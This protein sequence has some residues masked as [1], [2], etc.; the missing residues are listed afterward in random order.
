LVVSRKRANRFVTYA[1]MYTSLRKKT[2]S[3]I[4]CSEHG[5]APVTWFVRLERVSADRYTLDESHRSGI[6]I[7]ISGHSSRFCWFVRHRRFS[8]CQSCLFSALRYV[9][10]RT[11]ELPLL[12]PIP[13]MA[14]R[15]FYKKT[16]I[17]RAKAAVTKF[18]AAKKK[19]SRKT[20]RKAD[21]AKTQS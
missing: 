5:S 8:A 4:Q 9:L 7:N 1:A 19:A 16:T 13:I 12:F 14:K 17:A 18:R 21:R 6:H 10:Y 11:L 15:T 3:E 20:A 2:C